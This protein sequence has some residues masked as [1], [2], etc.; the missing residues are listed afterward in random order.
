[1]FVYQDVFLQKEK[2]TSDILLIEQHKGNNKAG[3]KSLNLY[4]SDHAYKQK[5]EF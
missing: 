3:K 4:S 2:Y 1:M 5:A